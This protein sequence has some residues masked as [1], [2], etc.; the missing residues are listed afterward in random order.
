MFIYNPYI[1]H[2]VENNEIFDRIVPDTSIIIEGLL[3]DK[4]ANNHFK[5]NEIIIHEAV[6][7]EL[8]HQANSGKAIG[9][10]G[11]DELKRIKQLS[12]EN[13]FQISFHGER[14]K[15]AEIR[16]AS[17]GEIDA[18]IRH[19]AWEQ[20]ATLV[21]SDKVQ[22]EVG[23]ARGMKIIYYKKLQTGLKKLKLEKFFDEIT[24][25]VHLRENVPPYAKKGMPGKWEFKQ[26][27]KAI[28]KQ[29]EIQDISRE[30]IEDAKLRKD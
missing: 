10:L 14:P 25:S 21:T 28:L 13:G 5:V 19:L 7:A 22:S 18:L 30:I 6:L 9:F 2:K 17:L 20:D 11:L 27:R 23:M 12:E 26:L 8:E 29:E 16:H 4:L 3:S 15:A 24:M 1:N